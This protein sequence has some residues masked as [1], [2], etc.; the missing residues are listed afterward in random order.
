MRRP[1]ITNNLK[2]ICLTSAMLLA[3][4]VHFLL[5]LRSPQSL[6]PVAVF[7]KDPSPHCIPDYALRTTLGT[8]APLIRTNPNTF[9]LSLTNDSGRRPV[10]A[11]LI[12][13]PADC[14]RRSDITVHVGFDRNFTDFSLVSTPQNAPIA[15][16]WNSPT[17]ST[18]LPW[19]AA[20]LNYKGTPALM[21]EL[22]NIYSCYALR[23]APFLPFIFL[24]AG[25]HW[26][27]H[28]NFH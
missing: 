6:N 1:K 16:K 20:A 3:M 7:D 4:L 18:F 13:R 24:G 22:F 12:N 19:N 25:H 17:A 28:K 11:L 26:A 5:I 27:R 14:N 21:L 8:T 23:L 2:A 9:E 10:S 15:T